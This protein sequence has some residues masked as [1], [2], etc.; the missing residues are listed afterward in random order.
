MDNIAKL[1]DIFISL[2]CKSMFPNISWI[3]FSVFTDSCKILDKN[4]VLSTIDRLFIATNVE[5]EQ[6]SENP[7]K[8]LCR[9]EFFE[10]LVRVA[11]AKFKETGIVNTHSEALNKLLQ[12]NVFPNAK[13][14][15]WQE[16]RD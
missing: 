10:I 2:A 4:V 9:Y 1:K 8:A 14:F 7:D 6:V 16:F 13:T 3:D 11:N 12:E 5:L 15:P